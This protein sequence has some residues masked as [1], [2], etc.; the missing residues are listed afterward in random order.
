M[1]F[2]HT[3]R[4]QEF[5][6][7]WS[8]GPDRP[9]AAQSLTDLIAAATHA[10]PDAIAVVHH[11]SGLTYRELTTRS[12]KLAR[13]LRRAGVGPET[14]VGVCLT[15]GPSM[16][17]GVLAVLQ[18]GGAYVP[19]DPALPVAR[20]ATMLTDAQAAVCLVDQATRGLLPDG[21]CLFIDPD[22]V[23]D[24]DSSPALIEPEY[25][26]RGGDLAYVIF[27][28]G[29]TGR[30]KGICVEQR[31]VVDFVVNNAADYQIR[32]GSRML[33]L[34]SIGFDVSVAEIFTALIAGATLIIADDEDR[35]SPSRL[36]A[37]LS[38]ERVTEVELPPS[39]L[40]LLDPVR[41]PD[42]RL[43]SVGG[44][45]PAASLVAAWVRAGKRVINAYGPTETTVT[46]TLM[47]CTEAE[48]DTV[49][50]G[51][52]TANHRAYVLDPDGDPVPAGESGELWIAGPGVAR[53]YL[54]QPDLTEDRFRPNPFEPLAGRMY[55]T[56]D[57]VRWN[58][59]GTLEFLGRVDG[60]LN[61]RGLRVEPGEV[62]SRLRAHP[63]IADAAVTMMGEGAGA[64]LVAAVRFLGETVT[65]PELAAWCRLTLPPAAVPSSFHQL[66]QLPL[67]VG[68]KVDRGSLQRMLHAD[69][70]GRP[71]P[72]PAGDDRERRLLDIWRELFPDAGVIGVDDDFFEIGG[73]SLLSMRMLVRLRAEFGVELSLGV[74][75]GARTVAGLALEIARATVAGSLDQIPRLIA[76]RSRIAPLS[77][78]QQQLW[79]LDRFAPGRVTYSLPVCLRL[80]GPVDPD[81]LGDAIAATA[82]RHEVLRTALVAT[83]NGPMAV[84]ADGPLSPIRRTDLSDVPSIER[85]DQ[86]RRIIAADIAA[87]F[88]LDVAPL[89]RARLVSVGPDDWALIFVVHHAIAD[90]WSLNLLLDELGLHYAR[91]GGG[92]PADAAQE[93]RRLAHQ[94]S[95][96]AAWQREHLV[97]HRLA[98]ELDHWQRA[99]SGAP[100]V[101]DLPSDRA[102]PAVQ[103]F[104]GARVSA[105]IQP[106]LGRRLL[107]L[108]G[109][110]RV[111]PFVAL[112]ALFHTLVGRLSGSDDV[113]VACPVVGRPDDSLESLIGFFV[114]T[115]PV[116]VKLSSADTIAALL[117]ETGKAVLDALSH[118]AVPFHLIVEAVA[119][120]RDTS[121]N[122]LVQ[123]A[124]NL[125]DYP[126]EQLRLAG[127]A[128]EEIPFDPPGSIFDLT[129]Y[130]R[131]SGDHIALDLVYNSDLFE[132]DRMQEM[133]DQ[134]VGLVSQAV[135]DIRPADLSLVTKTDSGSD[136]PM[137]MPTP[138]PT[139]VHRFLDWVRRTPTAAAI[140][141]HDGR[142]TY[143]ELDRATDALCRRLSGVGVG[144]GTVVAVA[145]ARSVN[146]PVAILA[147]RKLGA[148]VALVDAGFPPGRQ[149]E[150]ADVASPDVW[151]SLEK[152]GASDAVVAHLRQ[153][154]IHHLV[155]AGEPTDVSE[156]M[157]TPLAETADKSTDPAFVLFTSGTTG[158]PA[159]VV[160]P[161]G[162]LAH[163]IDWYADQFALSPRDRFVLTSGVAHDPVLRDVIVPLCLGAH[164]SIPSAVIHRAPDLLL[165]YLRDN[166]VSVLHLT[167]QLGRVLYRSMPERTSSRSGAVS[168]LRLVATG[169]DM[170]LGRD[171]A[172]LAA[173]APA[174]ELVSFYGTTE[175]PQAV[176]WQPLAGQ[177]RRVRIPIGSAVDDVELTV[178][179]ATGRRAG[180]GEPGELV[181]RSNQLAIGYLKDPERT[182]QRFRADP[183]PRHEKSYWTGDLA[184]Y[185]PDGRVEIVGRIDQQVK[186]RGFR[187][188][189]AEITLALLGQPG[190]AQAAVVPI[191]E[192]DDEV[193]LVGYVV[194]TRPGGDVGDLLGRL[195][196]VLPDPAV[197]S[198]IV[199]VPFIPMTANGKLDVGALPLPR[200]RA[201]SAAAFRE[202]R[203]PSER[204]IARIWCSVLGLTTVGIDDNFFDVGGTSLRLVD[205]QAR[206]QEAFNCALSIVD[207]FQCPTV[208]SLA[209]L[210]TPDGSAEVHPPVGAARRADVRRSRRVARSLTGSNTREF[211]AIPLTGH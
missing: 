201:A 98:T 208:R 188:E 150:L 18:A 128:V 143:R 159:G 163:F 210:L 28:S 9:V 6:E 22:D 1:Q 63:A 184:R 152:A 55:G 194:S 110:S 17:V 91:I 156:P 197:P 21:S 124:F 80:R 179:N 165:G 207:L 10:T 15:R 70:Q 109:R 57:R 126:P 133:L 20:L 206:L 162:A 26:G 129:M 56:G 141:A 99:L 100:R 72:R 199:S 77:F 191:R 87:P 177:D 192:P 136:A 171:V 81:V 198:A 103:S 175:T 151:I 176:A 95:D 75:A 189:L 112:L 101:L 36:Q 50:I 211:T 203:G 69:Q 114:N 32:P 97:G 61:V 48:V 170:L 168:S 200:G 96:F 52:P 42:L 35:L 186:V 154:G 29:S 132:A 76:R 27:T 120:P 169:G 43:V 115:V 85:E 127:V 33:A 149:I 46:A 60:Q 66:H 113:V 8:T 24:P 196:A 14:T 178:V 108:A 139:V 84:V 51:R 59:A 68:G 164:V 102:R 172:G 44:E 202:A 195:R 190:V 49:P 161:A 105:A 111:T 174:A 23:P 3:A 158:T 37:L 183:G 74:L 119:P 204:K 153:N 89:W 138:T 104:N 7:R 79:F 88:A 166:R 130:A 116:R 58:D 67:T 185:L 155:L 187:I 148:V 205:V 90:G 45:A 31:S 118:S 73:H 134:Y 38:A 182:A 82:A 16:V 86:L 30:P 19:L 25:V 12:T 13:R 65:F 4:Y 142:L 122:S 93:V 40:G 71:L 180:V 146:L 135:G 53:G 54:A 173:L 125:L 144:S 5:A 123:V 121:R 147:V 181:V 106:E 2:T 131:P 157:T 145:S 209:R 78:A 47:E 83:D 92:V 62:E 64:R 117:Q 140:T 39:L 11:G 167:P 94:Y 107:D 137:A 160:V 41:L 193:R 34:A